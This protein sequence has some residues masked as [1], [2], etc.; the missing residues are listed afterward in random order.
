MPMLTL[1]HPRDLFDTVDMAVF[2]EKAMA[3]VAKH[4]EARN[5]ITGEM[6]IFQSN[7]KVYID[8][9]LI[10]YDPGSSVTALCLGTLVTY[11]WLDRMVNL[12]DRIKAIT[13]GIRLLIP[14]AI[15]P[16]GMDGVSITFIPKPDGAWHAA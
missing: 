5:P 12:G 10:G 3:I 13:K 15:V 14:A 8:L 6:T 4:M 7:P 1:L 11:G 16:E 2:N 9:P